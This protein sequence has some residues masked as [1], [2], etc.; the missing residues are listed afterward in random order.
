M[1]G[2]VRVE[3]KG[4]GS[5]KTII[6]RDLW[7]LDLESLTW[8][9]VK[10]S[11]VHSSARFDLISLSDLNDPPSSLIGFQRTGFA[12]ILFKD[13]LYL[14]GGCTDQETAVDY[15]SKFHDDLVCFH[16]P[17]K[18]SSTVAFKEPT[19]SKQHDEEKSL[20]EGEDKVSKPLRPTARR[21]AQVC[22]RKNK[23]FVFG[24]AFEKSK[25]E[26]IYNDFYTIDLKK[27]SM[28]FTSINAVLNAIFF[29]FCF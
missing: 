17:S 10:R 16:I 12:P 29:C 2:G 21:S 23:M 25:R 11:G 27:V 15:I 13:N 5:E 6:L 1:Y 4:R 9:V 19:S 14:L 22:L 20:P 8:T 24:G 26:Y 7:Q 18:S 3:K 28:I